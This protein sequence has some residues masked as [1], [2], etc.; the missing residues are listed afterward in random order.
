M[1]LAL[2]L[3][4]ALLF[5]CSGAPPEPA[6]ARRRD[7]SGPPAVLP[8]RSAPL[9]APS[10]GFPSADRRAKL[11]K[12]YP[13]IDAA[14]EKRAREGK[15][16]GF[17][18]ALVIDGEVAHVFN[19]GVADKVTKKPVDS[20]TRFRIGSITK[21][22]TA[23]ALAKLRDEG[24][25]ASFEEPL[26]NVLPEMRVLRRPTVDA[27]PIRIRD[28][29]L[30]RSGL[31]RT[32]D[33]D[34]TYAKPID[35][36]TMVASLAFPALTTPYE[37]YSYSNYGYGLLGLAVE[38][39]SGESYEEYVVSEITRPLGLDSAAWN[40]EKVPAAHRARSYESKEGKLE[41]EWRLGYLDGAGGLY[42]SAK[43][44][45]RWAAFHA[46][47]FPPRDTR[48]DGPVKRATVRELLS[49]GTSDPPN[50]F[51]HVFLQ[52]PLGWDGLRACGERVHWKSGLVESFMSHVVF[53]PDHGVAFASL[54]TARM[55]LYPG[56]NDV[57][58][59]LRATGG[60]E[61]REQEPSAE[62]SRAAETYLSLYADYDKER[63]AKA[64]T[65][66]FFRFHDKDER[67][68][69]FKKQ[70]ARVGSCEL[71]SFEHV[72][73]RG[74]G[75]FRIRCERA[76]AT[77]SIQ[78]DNAL[79]L[80]SWSSGQWRYRPTAAQRDRAGAVWRALT[81]KKPIWEGIATAQQKI[82]Q[83][84]LS[85]SLSKLVGCKLGEE[86]DTSSPDE[87]LHEVACE[88][89]TRL[90]RTVFAEG[91]PKTVV[92]VA[93]DPKPVVTSCKTW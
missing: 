6:A 21:T 88:G 15:T 23:L 49:V 51:A 81:K 72:E 41:P 61:A 77:I 56:Q 46:D 14:L 70:L 30:H 45:A 62:L 85:A 5:A 7:V 55:N 89:E 64:Y 90:L 71:G 66:E 65:E 84:E 87:S 63:A 9:G 48:D 73:H 40:L 54:A 27:G 92:R 86:L 24:K 33:Y 93:L 83:A 50:D 68:A 79:S 19:Y 80:I 32:G 18:F 31:I 8:P 1:K 12:A 22:F 43:D 34:E 36:A 17:A 13:V 82:N 2:P 42:L 4:A 3:F 38:E 11:A 47:A 25:L 29:T 91:D 20:D 69:W 52:S 39:L 74:S 53:L 57:L 76:S 16:T 58:N 35:R 28:V 75:R 67:A 37:G 44:L 10:Y 26:E 59:A 78:L 60:L